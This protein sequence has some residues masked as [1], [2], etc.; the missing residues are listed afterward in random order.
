MND[1]MEFFFENIFPFIF[2][3]IFI[4]AIVFII[5]YGIRQNKSIIERARKID[6]SVKTYTEAQYVLQ[7][8]IAKDFGSNKDNNEK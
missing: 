7:K 1:F 6:P 8:D 2:A 3:G 4:F 5:V